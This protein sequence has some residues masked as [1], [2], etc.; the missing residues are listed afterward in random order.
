[1]HISQYEK[2]RAIYLTPPDLSNR[3]YVASNRCIQF[4][5]GVHI[6]LHAFSK[7]SEGGEWSVDNRHRLSGIP[8]VRNSKS[9]ERVVTS[10]V[11]QHRLNA[12]INQCRLNSHLF[13]AAMP[14]LHSGSVDHGFNLVSAGDEKYAIN[15]DQYLCLLHQCSLLADIYYNIRTVS[16]VTHYHCNTL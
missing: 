7:L 3:S 4:E 9:S 15:F 12:S 5:I 13:N 2:P 8:A 14:W 10:N 11:S 6:C 16:L 1:V